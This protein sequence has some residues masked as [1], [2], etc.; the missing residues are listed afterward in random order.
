MSLWQ[1]HLRRSG[2]DQ[3]FARCLVMSF[4]DQSRLKVTRLTIVDK[5]A[6]IHHSKI[7]ILRLAKDECSHRVM[8]GTAGKGQRTE[9]K[10]DD[11]SCHTR[12]ECADVVAA[13]YRCSA[14]GG[15]FERVARA[16]GCRVTQDALQEQ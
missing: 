12:S 9:I 8:D 10:A 3:E 1:N 11:V 15:E 5:N 7:Y 4:D 13:Q 2:P 14:E 16:H 6:A